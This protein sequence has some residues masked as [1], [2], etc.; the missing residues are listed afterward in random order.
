MLDKLMSKSKSIFVNKGHDNTELENYLDV[1][2]HQ[3]MFSD[4]KYHDGRGAQVT[5]DI[6]YTF[7]RKN[8]KPPHP[9][10][11]VRRRFY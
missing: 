7:G 2:Y 10:H 6:N 1:F 3:S 5:T 9:D 4:G 11:R 8:I